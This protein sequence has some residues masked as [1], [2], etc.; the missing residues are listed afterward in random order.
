MTQPY[1]W[2]R[3][4]GGFVVVPPTGGIETWRMVMVTWIVFDDVEEDLLG[5]QQVEDGWRQFWFW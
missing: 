3:N 1:G 5:K 4:S 2:P